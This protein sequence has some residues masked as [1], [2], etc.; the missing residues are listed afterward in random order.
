MW[1][2]LAS[3]ISISVNERNRSSCCRYRTNNTM[4]PYAMHCHQRVVPCASSLVAFSPVKQ[5][6]NTT[7]VARTSAQQRALTRRCLNW[8]CLVKNTSL[9]RE[10]APIHCTT[11]TFYK[12][13]HEASAF[14]DIY[15]WH[16]QLSPVW[17]CHEYFSHYKCL[18]PC[19]RQPAPGFYPELV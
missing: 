10:T 8:I 19:S 6:I 17:H 18:S 13:W 7:P 2:T 4:S 11:A 1:S 15:K 12:H 16:F 9:Q 3:C 5:P 14:R